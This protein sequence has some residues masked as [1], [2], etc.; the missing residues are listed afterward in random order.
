MEEHDKT[1]LFA[2]INSFQE[3]YLET[4][5]LDALAEYIDREVNDGTSEGSRKV[6]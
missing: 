4:E 3:F 6:V 1:I 2:I 5:I